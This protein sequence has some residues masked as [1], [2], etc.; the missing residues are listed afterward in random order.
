MKKEGKIV[1]VR[2]V[3]VD[4]LFEEGETPKVYDA[5]VVFEKD[6]T[7]LTL[8]VEAVLGYGLVRC[9]AMGNPFG[10]RRGMKVV[11]TG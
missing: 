1:A 6:F 3:V 5:L 7:P 10:L 2:G 8:E 9:V 11:N 4:V